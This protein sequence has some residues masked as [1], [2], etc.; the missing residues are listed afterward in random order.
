[1]DGKGGRAIWKWI[2]LGILAL[3]ALVLSM[4]VVIRAVYT[5]AVL[6]L[7]Y[8][9]GPFTGQVLPRDKKEPE[10]APKAEKKEKKPR[11]ETPKKSL[12]S[13]NRD[14]ICYPLDA[15]PP[16]LGGILRRLG[17][18]VVIRPLQVDL[19]LTGED[20]AD[21]ATLYGRIQAALEVAMPLLH[22]S[23][24]IKDQYIRVTPDFVG[25]RTELTAHVGVRLR[26]WHILV[27]LLTA[28]GSLVRVVL[29][30]RK[31]RTP[32]SSGVTEIDRNTDRQAAVGPEA[33]RGGPSGATTN[34]ND[35]ENR[36]G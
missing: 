23:L 26:L 27:I 10:P 24:C 4:P 16:I 7:S 20:P 8:G 18:G 19:L 13:V 31:L 30:F 15:V 9:V 12:P 2:L 17:R 14:Q 3:L 28:G 6:N 36:H 34:R 21:L 1:M 5:D 29:G 25:D 33:G 11:T 32:A 22:R 35:E